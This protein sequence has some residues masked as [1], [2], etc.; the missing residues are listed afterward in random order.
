MVSN[1]ENQILNLKN[2]NLSANLVWGHYNKL[3]F[4]DPKCTLYIKKI[5]KTEHLKAVLTQ[6]VHIV[7]LER[8][9][10]NNK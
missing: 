6:E 4:T 9:E 2:V 8:K 7:N 10:K 1:L 3:A 5:N